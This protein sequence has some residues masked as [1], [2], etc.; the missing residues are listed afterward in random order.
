[1]TTD[2]TTTAPAPNAAPNAAPNHRPIT[3]D[4]AA[5]TTTL[6][7]SR[8]ALIC[9]GRVSDLEAMVPSQWWKTVFADAMYLKTDGDVVEDPD[10][11]SEE[12][13]MLVEDA[14]LCTVFQHRGS[15]VLDLCCGQGRHALCL[16]E[17][18]PNLQL[19]GHDQSAYL[20][21][22][23]RERARLQGCA[24]TT[25]TVGDCRQI[26]YADAFFDVVLVMG[27]S[28]GYSR[29]DDGDDQVLKEIHRVLNNRH[30]HGN[31][32]RLLL[33]LTDG[34]FMRKHFVERSWEWIDDSCFV[35]RE[36]QL[37][38]DGTRLSS[39]EVITM[40]DLGVIRDQFYQERLYSRKEVEQML[41]S[42]GFDVV[43]DS[44]DTN[45]N[46]IT[47]ARDLSKR[48]EDLGM[49]E[50]RMC[51]K[52]VKSGPMLNGSSH[53]VSRVASSQSPQIIVTK[54]GATN[55]MSNSASSSEES[56]TS[57]LPPPPWPCSSP[58]FSD[59]IP[60]TLSLTDTDS[61]AN[62]VLAFPS[63]FIV[64]FGDTSISCVGKFNDAWNH[65]DLEARSKLIQA[66]EEL[67]FQV[68]LSG[69]GNGSKHYAGGNGIRIL[70][71]HAGLISE[72][73]ASRPGFVFNLCDEG[74]F[75]DAHKELHVP[76]VLD[77]LGIPYSGAGPNCLAVCY[78]K[79]LVNSTA[80]SIG[81]P[82]P[83]ETYYFGG[84]TK[85]SSVTDIDALHDSII[86]G[87]GYPAFV[88]PIKGDNSY[89]ISE[90]SIVSNR[91]ELEQCLDA[92]SREYGVVDAIVQEYLNGTEYSV[93]IIGNIE[94]G[95]HFLPT[96]EVD[97]SRVLEQGL[98]PILGYASK[99]DPMSAYWR[100]VSYGPA[101]LSAVEEAEL[102]ANCVILW[103]RFGCRD[104]ARFDFRRSSPDSGGVIKL[105]ET[106][107]NPGWCHDGKMAHM[108]RF[109]GR[110]YR[111]LVLM[112][113]QAAY[114]RLFAN[115]H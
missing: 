12:V 47:T 34:G 54:E 40:T 68:A 13:K 58:T 2:P 91:E 15:R 44:Y 84:F 88:K 65:E 9:H 52:A 80:S 93:G 30:G 86:K 102:H 112:L 72:L 71:K 43:E 70:E 101:K 90:R 25:F 55:A 60:T 11:T 69:R 59:R 37:S 18:F 114:Q 107:P 39:R 104:Y 74:Y 32:G 51:I 42:A 23:A 17:K 4:D 109:E 29:S 64:V 78:D 10:I 35:C 77:I 56:L 48:K 85:S 62:Q 45:G 63:N 33:D 108:A 97:Y 38:K 113:L 22:I 53:T 49:M 110:S 115:G 8:E 14:A 105:L 57:S 19:Y 75:N 27:N 98:A 50:Q 76:A 92:L 26:P 82:T 28:F 87:F 66:L 103:Q 111:E 61:A 31:T 100:D 95:L 1:M 79:G 24:N 94:S 81:I 6:S 83:R 21:S 41:Y 89:G 20:I 46:A 96:M 99:W 36:R 7:R 3:D 73:E 5:C 67:G 106:N 16:A